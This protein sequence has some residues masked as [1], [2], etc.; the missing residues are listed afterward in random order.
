MFFLQETR[1][2]ER[3]LSFFFPSTKKEHPAEPVFIDLA[4]LEEVKSEKIADLKTSDITAANI[5]AEAAEGPTISAVL[6]TNAATKTDL[7]STSTV[8]VGKKKADATTA[9]AASTT[10]ATTKSAAADPVYI[11]L[12]TTSAAVPTKVVK[13]TVTAAAAAKTE[14]VAEE[15]TTAT[16]ASTTKATTKSAAAEPVYIDLATT[17]AAVPTKVVK[18]TVTAATAAKTEEVAEEATTATTASTT[19]ATTKSAAVDPVYID[20]AS[21]SAAVPTKVVKKTVTAATAA[22]TEE[23]AEEATTATTTSASKA[24][25]MAIDT[26]NKVSSTGAFND[27][28]TTGTTTL[29]IIEED[30]LTKKDPEFSQLVAEEVVEFASTASEA[31]DSTM[32]SSQK[33][34]YVNVISAAGMKSEDA[35]VAPLMPEYV[36]LA[37][38]GKVKEQAELKIEPSSPKVLSD[39]KILSAEGSTNLKSD[40]ADAPAVRGGGKGKHNKGKR[41]NLRG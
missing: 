14:E 4:P 26:K 41:P 11:D 29:Q 3:L 24:T 1:K 40:E 13:K 22:K 36:E 5:N 23:V 21:T 7:A 37:P 25:T 8:E 38:E 12:A 27:L 9:T 2:Y 39:P 34:V 33:P 30:P 35:A 6:D 10:K 16:T 32:I 18:K 28:G 15:A 20:L 17:S 19:K 31:T